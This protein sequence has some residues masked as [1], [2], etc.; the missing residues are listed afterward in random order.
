VYIYT[1]SFTSTLDEG[2]W[3]SPRAGRFSPGGDSVPIAYEAG[4]VW[5][6]AKN[7][8]ST[9]IRSSDL[10]SRSESPY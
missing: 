3:S 8:A 4:W 5:T 9:G 6:G 1:P 7:L 10:P 2:G